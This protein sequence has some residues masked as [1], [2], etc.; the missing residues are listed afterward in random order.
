MLFGDGHIDEGVTRELALSAVRAG[1]DDIEVAYGLGASGRD[2]GEDA[3]CGAVRLATGAPRDAFVAEAMIP[4]ASAANPPQNWKAPD[5]ETL[6]ASPIVGDRGTTV[7]GAIMA[8]LEP[9]GQFIRQLEGLGQ[10]LSGTHGVFSVPVVGEWLSQ[11][12][13]QA[14]HDG[15]VEPLSRDPAPM[16]LDLVG[17]D[18]PSPPAALPGQ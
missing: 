15:F 10:G 9:G 2:L 12:C 16:L 4:R 8:M 6:W 1:N 7:G 18:G 3:L 17:D 13:C 11:R 14:F 5:V